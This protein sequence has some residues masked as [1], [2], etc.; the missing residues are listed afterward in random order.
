MR[1]GEAMNEFEAAKRAIRQART[2]RGWATP[3]QIFGWIVL[4]ISALS[5]L[6]GLIFAVAAIAGSSN[7]AGGILAGGTG[8]LL[9]SM[10]IFLQAC[11]ILMIAGYVKM[12]AD[13]V[14]F[15]MQSEINAATVD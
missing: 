15:R 13:D 8:V 9:V 11:V 7:L 6:V 10:V 2:V 4:V 3:V 1:L 14:L 5:F 12:K